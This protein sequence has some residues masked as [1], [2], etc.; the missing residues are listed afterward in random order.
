MPAHSPEGQDIFKVGD[1]LA[2]MQN[3]EDTT[4]MV[5]WVT[6]TFPPPMLELIRRW[7]LQLATVG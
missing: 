7:Q 4:G 5:C 2:V 1:L 3:V 6:Y